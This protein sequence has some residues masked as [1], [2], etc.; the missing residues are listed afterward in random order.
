MGV[1][2]GEVV[3]FIFFIFFLFVVLK[4]F[5]VDDDS[6]GRVFEVGFVL[7]FEVFWFDY[8]E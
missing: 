5:V 8:C 2:R 6:Y 1:G 7:G 3:F 4:C